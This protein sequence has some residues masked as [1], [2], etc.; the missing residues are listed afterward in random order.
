MLAQAVHKP[1]NNSR[2]IFHY[3]RGEL[4][5]KAIECIYENN[6]LKPVGKVQ[7]REGERI[8][9]TIEKKLPFEP[10]QLKKKPSS[11]RISALRDE[12]WISS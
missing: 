5:G 4:M 6:V 12:S 7:L 2:P 8:R 10:I 3:K 11:G 1:Y 9:V